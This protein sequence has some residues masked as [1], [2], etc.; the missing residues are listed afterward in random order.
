MGKVGY[1][2]LR[3]VDRHLAPPADARKL[4][5]K[6][7]R[8]ILFMV[9][10]GLDY[11]QVAEKLFITHDTVKSHLRRVFRALGVHDKTEAVA[12]CLVFDILNREAV[13]KGFLTRL[14]EEQRAPH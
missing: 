9:A 13:K 12:Y 14:A 4:I 1:M 11:F 10:C 2:A 7:Q 8:E 5:S 6:R 3:A